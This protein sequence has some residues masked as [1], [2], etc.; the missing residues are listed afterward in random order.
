MSAQDTT[1]TTNRYNP[2]ALYEG[3]NKLNT[4]SVSVSAG[5][6]QFFGDLRQYDFWPTGENSD[7]SVSERGAFGA[8]VYVNKQLSHLF[9]ASLIGDIGTLKGTKYRIYNSYFKA[10]YR[11]LT[12]VGKANL[13]S[14]FFGSR[15]LNRWKFD[16]YTGA[17]VMWFK[18]IA[19]EIN[20]TRANPIK[21][22]TNGDGSAQFYGQNSPSN[23]TKELVI[24]IGLWINYELTPRFDLGIDLGLNNVNTEKLDATVGGDASSAYDLTGNRGDIYSYRKGLSDL[25]KW[26]KLAISVTYKLGKNAISAG[27]DRI[28]DPARGTYHLRYVDPKLLIKPPK[29]LTIEEIDSVAKANRPKDIDP[30]LL[31][32]SDNDGVSDF[33]D[34]QPNTPPGSIV[35]G[36]GEAIDFEKIVNNII[37]GSGCMEIFANVQFDTDKSIILPQYQE[38]LN[39]IV[40]LMNRT[41]CRLQLTGHADRRASDRYNMG[42]A[43]RRVQSVKKYLIN[44]GLNNPARIITDS[45]G[46]FK[47][48]ADNA[49]REGLRKNR[50]VELRFLP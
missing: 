2:N 39:R 31:L 6:P 15:K 50:R 40:E 38:M 43:E 17:G 5:S 41:P 11:Q 20:S 19:Y 24:P 10:D 29:I 1:S 48:V 14:L 35:S 44:A 45:F 4:W 46:A 9:G 22:F 16:F 34:K 28:Y 33:F 7:K 23:W 32:D 26:G 49:S 42:L 27:K 36:S 18:S 47:P 8:S 3:P 25:D 37:P 30:R 13:K 12:L 21:R